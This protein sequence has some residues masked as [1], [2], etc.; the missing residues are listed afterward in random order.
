MLAPG[1]FWVLLCMWVVCNTVAAMQ[2]YLFFQ[3]SLR[4]ELKLGT[5]SYV[6]NVGNQWQHKFWLTADPQP[7]FNWRHYT[8]SQQNGQ[9]ADCVPGSNLESGQH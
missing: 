6:C 7:S 4:L 1:W 2:D 8:N 9:W 5:I 3:A